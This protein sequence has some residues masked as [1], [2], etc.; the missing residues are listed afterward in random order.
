MAALRPSK[1]F[2]SNKCKIKSY[3]IKHGLP[4]TWVREKP[5]VNPIR[6]TQTGGISM[7]TFPKD[8][9]KGVG[10]IAYDCQIVQTDRG[11]RKIYVNKAT[12]EIIVFKIEDG[13][14]ILLK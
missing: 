12:G 11:V 4:L 1:K 5:Y 3:R 14:E 8:W 6:P 2:C 7:P 9:N 10:G 13:K